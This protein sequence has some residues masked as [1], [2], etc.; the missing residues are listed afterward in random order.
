MAN[1]ETKAR[2]IPVPSLIAKPFWDAAK[3]GKFMLQYDPAAGKYQFYPR[4]VSIYGGN[5]KLEWREAS[6]RGTLV[7]RTRVRVPLKG[8]EELVPFVLGA[9]DLDEGVRVVARLA[10]V[11][12]E[13]AKPGMKV[14]VCWEDLAGGSK[15]FMF[16]PVA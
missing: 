4:P 8:F 1:A 3:Q 6:G 9:V 2:P 14:R 13:A 12:Y 10:C 7:S 15:M 5:G 16:V 11:S